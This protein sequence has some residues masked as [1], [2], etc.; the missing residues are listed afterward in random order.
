MTDEPEIKRTTT[1]AMFADGVKKKIMKNK[2]EDLNTFSCSIVV[3][4][5]VFVVCAAFAGWR[6]IVNTFGA[7]AIARE[8]K[9]A[10]R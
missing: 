5:F 10:Q 9:E 1:Q 8:I 7:E 3:I 4:W 2:P 6:L